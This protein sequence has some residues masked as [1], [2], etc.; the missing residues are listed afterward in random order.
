MINPEDVDPT[1]GR[2]RNMIQTTVIPRKRPHPEQGLMPTAA[3]LLNSPS[4]SSSSSSHAANVK[5]PTF[6]SPTKA[7][8]GGGGGLYDGLD[9]HLMAG[10]SGLFA[11]SLSSIG[12]SWPVKSK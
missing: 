6:T 1:I 12:R 11:T 8:G 3:D 4:E 10:P 7:V 5:R 9:S 2:F